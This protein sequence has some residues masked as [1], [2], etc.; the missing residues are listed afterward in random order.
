MI[1]FFPDVYPDELVYSWFARYGVRT[2]YTHYRAIADDLFTSHTAKPNLEFIIELNEDAYRT[3]TRIMPFEQVIMKHTMFPYYARFLPSERRQRAF[4]LIMGMDKTFYDAIYIRRN[5]TMHRQWLRYC[6]LCVEADRERYGE[7][8]WHRL[9][10]LD[11]IDICPI[12]GCYLH[13]SSISITS[14]DSPSLIHAETVIPIHLAAENCSNKIELEVA[15]YVLQV[16]SAKLD[17]DND[18]SIGAFLHYKM[19]HT[20]YLSERGKKRLLSPL[21]DDF[22]EL[23]SNLPNA[24]ITEQWQIEKI[25]SNHRCHTYDICLLAYF[26]GIPATELVRMKLPEKTQTQLF[27]EKIIALHEL[28]LNYRQISNQMGAS[29]DYCKL[30]GN[31]QR[32]KI[33]SQ[34]ITV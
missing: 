27:D 18:A 6:P 23:Y 13:N 2:G 28:G 1:S 34:H 10:Q 12:H 7:T 19:E 29:Y 11:H 31:R 14:K 32:K 15:R 16:F 9:H 5:K 8:Y 17:I 21:T 4:D 33:S 20:K 22:N 3:I 24:T 26:L 25:F 30:V